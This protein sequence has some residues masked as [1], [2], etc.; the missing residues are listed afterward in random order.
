MSATPYVK[1]FPS[2]FL[3][4][5]ADLDLAEIAVYTI[6]LNLIYDRNGPLDDDAARIGRRCQIRADKCER[7]LER[8]VSL[9]KIIRKDGKITNGRAAKELINRQ[10]KSDSAKV[11]AQKRWRVED[12]KHKKINDH[13][14]RSDVERICVSDANQS[15]ESRVQILDFKKKK[16]SGRE[17]SGERTVVAS[18][19][20]SVD[21][22][23]EPAEPK[24]RRK[25]RTSV[26]K[27]FR[28][29]DRVIDYARS[30]NF[31][32]G[33]PIQ[34]MLDAFRNYHAAKGSLMADWFAAWRTWVNNEVKYSRPKSVGQV[35]WR[36]M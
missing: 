25:T 21:L 32:D 24:S 22:L 5:I 26:E 34:S 6:I 3:Q 15:P 8:L 29:D 10:L 31:A 14:M 13:E 9:G 20:P 30:K 7:V 4:G 11:S 17:G 35:V 16:D 1:W 23:G 36:D 33:D 27:G 12:E 28:I 18:A 2:D 19:P